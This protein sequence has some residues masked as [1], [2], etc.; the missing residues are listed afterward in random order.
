MAADPEKDRLTGQDTTGHEWDGIKELNT[1]LPRWWLYIFYATILF[2]LVYYV[3]YPAIPGLYGY[4][5]GILGYDQREQLADSLAD[6]AEARAAFLGRI[7]DTDLEAIP[8]DPDL[9]SYALAGGATAFADNCVPCHGLGGAGQMGGYP[10]LA[11]DAWLWGGTLEA[12]HYTLLHGIRFDDPQTRFS[13]MPAFGASGMLDDAQVD[14]VA[15]Y[16]LSLS[17]EAEDPEAAARGEMIYPQCAA[18]H[19]QDGSGNVM[20]GAPALNDRIW[21]YG[22]THEE[23]AL[24]VHQPR[25]GVM[26]AWGNRLSPETI[27]MLTVYVH[28]LGGGQ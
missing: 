22:G 19:G 28:A 13:E 25:H 8:E 4:T 1:P 3:L 2:S 12:I 7:A 18:C 14:D 15:H 27:K 5:K 20:L 10:N 23:I 6:V 21:L 16:V 24:Q 9:L 17:G 11:D 26:P